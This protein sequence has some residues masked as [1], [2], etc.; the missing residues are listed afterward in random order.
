MQFYTKCAVLNSTLC[1]SNFTFVWGANSAPPGL[2]V[3]FGEG[4]RGKGGERERREGKWEKKNG[5]KER[6]QLEEGKGNGGGK[7]KRIILCSCDFSLK[8][9][10]FECY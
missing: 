5:G 10:L 7:G 2:L 6:G 1:S 3:G 8:T 9:Y 4:R